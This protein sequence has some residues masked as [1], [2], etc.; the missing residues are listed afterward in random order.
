MN[1]PTRTLRELAT[2]LNL[3]L[4][5]CCMAQ[6]CMYVQQK[7]LYTKQSYTMYVYSELTLNF[8]DPNKI[9]INYTFNILRHPT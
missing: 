3:F 1:G 6:L 7:E 5:Q 2:P 4:D 9:T 8:G